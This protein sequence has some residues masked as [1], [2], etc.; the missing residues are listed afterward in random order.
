MY[1]PKIILDSSYNQNRVIGILFNHSFFFFFLLSTEIAISRI[2]LTV[3]FLLVI[4]D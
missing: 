1:G 2:V 4:G 3:L